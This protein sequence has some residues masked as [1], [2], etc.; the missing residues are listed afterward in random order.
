MGLAVA[1]VDPLLARVQSNRTHGPA[2]GPYQLAGCNRAGGSPLPWRVRSC[3][4][5]VKT[6]G[7]CE[8]RPGSLG[9]RAGAAPVCRAYLGLS[10]VLLEHRVGRRHGPQQKCIALVGRR[11]CGRF[12][13]LPGR[14]QGMCRWKQGARAM[15]RSW[16]PR[17]TG[18]V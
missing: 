2:T 11:I 4:P 8:C 7:W 5:G 3:S 13:T 1:V 15:H 16:E 14:G 12:A 9:P 10:W 18:P 17:P 6:G